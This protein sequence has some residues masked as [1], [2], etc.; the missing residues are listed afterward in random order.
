MRKAGHRHFLVP[1]RQCQAEHLVG[2]LGVGF[3]ELVEVPHAEQEQHIGML[4]FRIAVL[5]HHGG[6]HGATRAFIFK[7]INSEVYDM[8]FIDA[9]MQ[10]AS[11][12]QSRQRNDEGVGCLQILDEF[13]V[14]RQ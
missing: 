7:R 5:L 6:G 3:K 1:A 9:K 8:R 10:A 12:R 13:L 14:G 11:S 4:G 2:G